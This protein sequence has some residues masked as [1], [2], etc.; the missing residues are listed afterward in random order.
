VQPL[1]AR[2]QHPEPGAPEQRTRHERTDVENVLAVVDHEEQV[3]RGQRSAEPVHRVGDLVGIG[4]DRGEHRCGDQGRVPDLGEVD[5]GHA[6]GKVRCRGGCHRDRQPRLADP[7]RP[8]QRQLPCGR[9]RQESI[10]HGQIVV[11]SHQWVRRGRKRTMEWSARP[12]HVRSL[13]RTGP[14][15]I[16]CR[17]PRTAALVRRWQI[18]RP[19][20]E[21]FANQ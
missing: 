15:S 11:P 13:S 17:P 1:P 12:A 3:L 19:L 2:R 10:D 4:T 14:G 16:P 8:R 9:V 6:V 5:E 20:D 7:G 18:A 21:F